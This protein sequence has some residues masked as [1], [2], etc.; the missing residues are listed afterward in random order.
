[1]CICDYRVC[2][3]GSGLLGSVVSVKECKWI[4]GKEKCGSILEILRFVG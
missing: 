2:F 1:M 4:L 3:S